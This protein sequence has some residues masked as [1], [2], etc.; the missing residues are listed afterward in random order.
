MPTARP[1]SRKTDISP[2]NKTTACKNL[3]NLLEIDDAFSEKNIEDRFMLNRVGLRT[4]IIGMV[5]LVVVLALTVV[6]AVVFYNSRSGMHRLRA[7]VSDLGHEVQTKQRDKLSQVE[8]TLQQ[9]ET[10]A[11]LTKGRSLAN[12]VAGLAAIPL[13]TYDTALLDHYCASVSHDPDVV[14]CYITDTSN[15]VRSTFTNSSDDTLKLF[16]PTEISEL[17]AM[18][19]ALQ[20]NDNLV[21]NRS[22]IIQDENQ[23][24]DV[25]V[26][27]QNTAARNADNRFGAFIK[28]TKDLFLSM[29]DRIASEVRLQSR[30]IFVA[31]CGSALA[32]VGIAFLVLRVTLTRRI[33]Q[34]L[35]KAVLMAEELAAG[36]FDSRMSVRRRDEIGILAAAFNQMADSLAAKVEIAQTIAQGDLTKELA[37]VSEKDT[38]GI[39]LRKM[40]DTIAMML[41]QINA[42]SQQIATGSKQV[43]VAAQSLSNQASTQSA[44]IEKIAATLRVINE[45][46]RQHA[47]DTVEAERIMQATSQSAKTCRER[48]QDTVH[49]MGEISDSSNEILKII[50]TIDSIAFQTNLLALNASVEAARAGKHG[51]GFAVVAQEVRMLAQRSAMAASETAERITQSQKKVQQGTQTALDTSAVLEEIVASITRVAELITELSE[52]GRDQVANVSEIDKNMG[53][54]DTVS[55]GNAAN[56]EE[57]TAAATELA[58]QAQN[59]RKMLQQ[60]VIKG[61]QRELTNISAI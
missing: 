2:S 38:L 59:L 45:R 46:V 36:Q 28:E 40:A 4:Q 43:F 9:S 16:V 22:P 55:H 12:L 44:S 13:L 26:I 15:A 6:V 32:A 58:A 56:A 42:S 7:C 20:K 14:L 47:E 53:E 18:I 41:N 17:D 48:M 51:K 27:L 33:I 11:L 25:V 30:L 29:K 23:L 61:E 31:G 52:A 34:P 24:G 35:N 37:L 39:A 10:A 5:L 54:I 49:A 57:T 19:A 21:T 3:I 60:F 1:L 8:E 50:N